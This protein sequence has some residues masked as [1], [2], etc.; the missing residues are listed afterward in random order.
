ML[1]LLLARFRRGVQKEGHVLAPLAP[2]QCL[3][4]GE[5][6]GRQDADGLVAYLPAVAVRAVQHLPS[7]PLG[8]A[9]NVGQLIDQ[10][11]GHQQ[12]LRQ[13][14]AA[15]VEDDAEAPDVHRSAATTVPV[16]IA[17]PYPVTSA[18]PAASSSAG[19]VPSRA[20]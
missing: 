7:P 1:V 4:D 13:D 8:H 16:R 6:A 19:G 17:P 11:G 10:A 5:G 15:A 14:R 18:R 20:R 2:Q 9:G 3:V 12:P